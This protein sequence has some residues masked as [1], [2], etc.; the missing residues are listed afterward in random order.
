MP[1]EKRTYQSETITPLSLR[2]EPLH[3]DDEKPSQHR[4][5]SEVPRKSFFT[6][7]LI[8]RLTE[9]IKKL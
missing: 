9:R 4:S 6:P 1:K 5:N 8:S 2:L 7:E 3:K